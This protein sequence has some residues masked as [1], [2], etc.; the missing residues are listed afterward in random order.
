MHPS[1][2]QPELQVVSQGDWEKQR[3]FKNGH[4]GDIT[5]AAWSPNGALLATTGLDRTLSL[6][7]VRTQQ[8]LCTYDDVRDTILALAWHNKDNTLSYT[9]TNG[10]LFIHTDFVPSEHLPL[11]KQSAQPAPFI[12]DPLSET[13][14]NANK[15]RVN[16]IPS[17]HDVPMRGY[18]ERDELD[19][20][21]G[22]DSEDGDAFIVD[23]DG[24]GY[25]EDVP[26]SRKRTNGHL[27]NGD[28]RALKRRPAVQS[29]KPEFHHPFQP[30]STPWR[31]NRKYLCLNLIGFAWTVD[32]SEGGRE[33]D[34]YH[35]VTVEFYDREFQRDFKFRE[36]KLYD[37]ACL[38]EKGSL[39]SC[40]PDEA[41]D[42]PATLY[43]RPHEMWTM[44]TEWYIELPHGE[45][46]TS[47]ALS[48]SFIVVTTSTNYVRVYTLF[49][50][51]FRV[52]RQK[53]SPT[54]T[55]AAWRDYV[56]TI[57]NGPVAGDGRAQ[58]LYTIENVKRDEICQSDD[59]VALP[60]DVGL[61]S[62]FFS[63]NG[64]GS[65]KLWLVE[66]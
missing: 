38:N 44:R 57:G 37:K 20:L 10:E 29:W 26:Q 42:L 35:T 8:I 47:M 30:G 22:S 49:G 2:E 55:C 66:T 31:G 51:P 7:D 64:V 43:Y 39:F 41:R 56:L 65:T 36:D 11:L 63:D 18:G 16:G 6:W 54:V 48:D 45:S 27:E 17:K 24:A 34:N 40:P 3:A 33:D 61:Q 53:T 12:H 60:E 25:A 28:H 46:V 52:Y 14:G 9:N 62:V 58:L 23:D 4:R 50:V 32:N 21:L 1:D 19:D 15:T 13:S 5:A 59:I